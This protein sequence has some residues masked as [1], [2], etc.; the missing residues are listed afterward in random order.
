M[1]TLLYWP[2]MSVIIFTTSLLPDIASLKSFASFDALP[3]LQMKMS[4][5]MIITVVLIVK[6]VFINVANFFVG[7]A[8]NR[9]IGQL[10]LPAGR[11]RRLFYFLPASQPDS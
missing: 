1:T 4:C 10:C 9:N 2:V 5:T 8:T 6:N 11:I 7:Q 3:G